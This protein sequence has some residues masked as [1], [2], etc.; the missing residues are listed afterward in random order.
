MR[1]LQRRAEQNPSLFGDL[2]RRL[3]SFA[4]AVDNGEGSIR[5]RIEN[6]IEGDIGDE[7]SE[8]L[9]PAVRELV[10]NALAFGELQVADVMVQRPDIKAVPKDASLAKVLET[11]QAGMHTRLPV[12]GTALDDVVGM[13]HV[14]D[15]LPYFANP[16]GFDLAKVTR[17]VLVV[18]PSMSVLALVREMRDTRVHMAVVVDEFGGTD[19]LAT[20]EDLV[21]EIIG[22]IPDE[23]DPAT[24][25]Q[26]VRQPDGTI[27]VDGRAY[28][29]DLEQILGAELLDEETREEVDTVSGLIS[30][31]VDRIPAT[32][33]RIPHPAGFTFEILDA[34]SRRIERVKI[35]DQR[36][37]QIA[38]TEVMG[39]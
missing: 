22:E 29:D 1:Q 20:M 12:Y 6:I 27:D 2:M 8:K 17:R 31:L 15:L 14:K 25:A 19:G 35:H 37:E 39:D 21:G 13:V 28:L 36:A 10:L 7:N 32:G 30:S 3:R 26:I 23:H 18:P 11:M 4:G 34:S 5:T 24:E 16:D 33:E 38:E 9:V